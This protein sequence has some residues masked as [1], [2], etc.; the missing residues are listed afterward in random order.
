M[1]CSGPTGPHLGRARSCTPAFLH[2]QKR[3]QLDSISY[4]DSVHWST[5][6]SNVLYSTSVPGPILVPC[7]E[8]SY[9]FVNS[10]ASNSCTRGSQVPNL[11]QGL[12][13]TAAHISSNRHIIRSQGQSFS[14]WHLIL[15]LAWLT[16]NAVL[17][18]PTVVLNYI[19]PTRLVSSLSQP[20]QMH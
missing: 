18:Y 19:P 3:N 13:P 6:F 12:P 11:A 9:P 2:S 16:M 5:P 14:G 8:I 10:I 17:P 4:V 15:L 7:S 1:T 20:Y